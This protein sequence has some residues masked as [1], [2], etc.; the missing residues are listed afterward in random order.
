MPL[1]APPARYNEPRVSPDGTQVAVRVDDEDE[2]NIWIYDI[3]GAAAPR[4]LTFGG[5]N[6]SPSWT[7]DGRRVVFIS[8]RE[9]NAN[10]IFVQAADG[11][12]SAERLTDPKTSQPTQARMGAHGIIVYRDAVPPHIRVLRLDADR[13]SE[14]VFEA[15]GNQLEG[16]LS[17]DGRWLAY[18]SSEAGQTLMIFVQPYPPTGAKYQITTTPTSDP[19]WSPDGRRLF[20]TDTTPNP[21][22][23]MSL[24]VRADSGFTTLGA[25]TLVFERIPQ[26]ASWPFDVTPDGTGFVMVVNAGDADAE[27]ANPEIRVTLNWFEEL[28]QRVPR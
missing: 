2:A 27:R 8:N 14:P 17:P 12:G 23:L 25:P 13:K 5:T 6:T 9:G 18:T 16:S 24:D 4:R 26:A 19:L 3:A 20:Y 22:L 11:S 15:P 28:R 21:D 10:A 1:P 7:P